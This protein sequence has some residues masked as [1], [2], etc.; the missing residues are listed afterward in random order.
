V[1]LNNTTQAGMLKMLRT[2]NNIM[3]DFKLNRNKEED[4]PIFL[5][6]SV[7]VLFLQQ[8]NP[9]REPISINMDQLFKLS[10]S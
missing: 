10:F 2:K 9:K 4:N 7:I 3:N 6:R 5:F 8:T 1:P